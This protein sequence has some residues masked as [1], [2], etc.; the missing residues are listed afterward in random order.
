MKRAEIVIFSGGILAGGVAGFALCWLLLKKKFD[1]KIDDEIARLNEEDW[2]N[3][4]SY[5]EQE[6][7]VND[8]DLDTDPSKIEENG[9]VYHKLSEESVDYIEFYK[10][11]NEELKNGAIKLADPADFEHPEDD[12]A[13]DISEYGDGVDPETVH[14]VNEENRNL[15]EGY[16]I[17]KETAA[18]KDKKPKIITG[19][20]Y[21]NEF[22]HFDKI[23]LQYYFDDDILATEEDE[24]IDDVERILGDTLDKYGFRNNDESVIYVRNVAYG[25]DYEVF[26][27]RAAFGEYSRG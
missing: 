23:A 21:Y 14:V 8:P 3:N 25:T 2:N 22:P 17:S 12:M 13:D 24:E 16:E 26:K 15:V 19:D 11:K 7:E 27:V 1:K 9:R 6:F 5:F 10:K 18:G 20:S 4:L